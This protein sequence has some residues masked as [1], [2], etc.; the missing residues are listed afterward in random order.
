MS[1]MRLFYA[2]WPA[3]P[4]AGKLAEWARQ[5]APAMGGRVMR[6][7]TLHLTLAFLGDI[8]AATAEELIDATPALRVQP[9]ALTLDRYGVF[10]R[11]RIL[12]AGPAQTPEALQALYDGLWLW[13]SG[14][15]Q[16]PPTQPFGPHVTL[17]RH[18]ETKT[19]PEAVPEPLTWRYDRLVLAA[20][21]SLT[22]GSR[23]RVVAQTA[24]RA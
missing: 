21:E 5:A 10:A 12:W 15:G 18:I 23:Y 4:L 3:A 2:L 14:Y 13:L 8:D 20:S 7:E 9:G 24:P 6:T 16:Q 1:T 22:G 11:Q 19:P 17:A